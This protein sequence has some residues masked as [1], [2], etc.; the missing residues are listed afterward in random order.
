MVT[1]KTVALSERK[2]EKEH[3]SIKGKCSDKMTKERNDYVDRAL[4]AETKLSENSRPDHTHTLHSHGTP[5]QK[6]N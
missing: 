5:P 6:K 1:L 2:G 3:Y 4:E